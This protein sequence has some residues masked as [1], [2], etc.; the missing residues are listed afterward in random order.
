M[1]FD[2]A[3]GLVLQGKEKRIEIAKNARIEEVNAYRIIGKDLL[4]GDVHIGDIKTGE[5]LRPDLSS[6][7]EN[8][9]NYHSINGLE[10]VS[11]A[12]AS[13]FE[14]LEYSRN[15][16]IIML[17]LIKLKQHG[18]TDQ[19]I[20][21]L[22]AKNYIKKYHEA[23]SEQFKS[24]LNTLKRLIIKKNER[25]PFYIGKNGLIILNHS[26]IIDLPP[27][28]IRKF[29]LQHTDGGKYNLEPVLFASANKNGYV[30]EISSVGAPKVCEITKP[31]TG[32][33]K[34]TFGDLNLINMMQEEFEDSQS[35][36]ELEL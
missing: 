22:Y 31:F 32:N 13:E 36:N 7:L 26:K 23:E 29:Y 19:E 8:C 5:K 35:S 15:L 1:Q 27:E 14:E 21:K 25:A 20:F 17:D 3:K 16:G 24:Y 30:Y 2:S 28:E 4:C 12:C 11:I 34:D 33:G 9:Q 6:K 10:V 18:Y